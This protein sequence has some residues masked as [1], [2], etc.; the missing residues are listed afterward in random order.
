MSTDQL[1]RAVCAVQGISYNGETSW[2]YAIQQSD[3]VLLEVWLSGVHFFVI[4][5]WKWQATPG[6]TEVQI[7]GQLKGNGGEE[8]GIKW[9]NYRKLGAKAFSSLPCLLPLLGLC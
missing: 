9:E 2:A 8:G 7:R 1:D 4:T 3:E 6:L 5:A